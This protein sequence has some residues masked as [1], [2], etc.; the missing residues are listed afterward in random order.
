MHHGLKKK[1]GQQCSGKIK[2]LGLIIG[3]L[4]TVEEKLVEVGRNGHFMYSN[5]KLYSNT[6]HM[7]TY[8]STVFVIC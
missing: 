5:Y 7:M 1:T 8:N 6:P 3:R 2:K 4:N